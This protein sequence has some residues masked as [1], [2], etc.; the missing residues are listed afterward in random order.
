MLIIFLLTCIDC[1]IL[2]IDY[3]FS[4][5]KGALKRCAPS[6]ERNFIQRFFENLGT[7]F[8]DSI[9]SNKLTVLP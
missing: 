9:Q 2:N 8:I 1:L 6:T 3:L 4:E 7:Y 5:I